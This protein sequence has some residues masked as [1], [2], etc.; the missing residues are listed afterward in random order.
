[1]TEG[2][3]AE[4]LSQQDICFL[5]GIITD[6]ICYVEKEPASGETVLAD[7]FSR[8]FGG[9]GANQCIMAARLGAKCRMLGKVGNDPNGLET[10]K[11]FVEHVV[12]KSAIEIDGSSHTGVALISVEK[13]SGNN[14]I[15]VAQGANKNVDCNYIRFFASVIRR[16]QILMAGMEVPQDAVVEALKIAKGAGRPTILNPAPVPVEVDERIYELADYICPNESEAAQLLGK[17][18][19][20]I[21]TVEDAKAV[22]LELR[23]KGAKTIIITLG[24]KGCVALETDSQEP[25]H[26]EARS[27]T[28]VDT[29]G[30]G[31][32]F[33]GSFAYFV[34]KLPQLSLM[35][36]IKRSGA[37]ASMS[38]Q[39]NGTQLSFPYR[40]ELNP[41]LF[42]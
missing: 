35:E 39:K 15:I 7:E 6:F 37:I 20:T 17:D 12:E 26:V 36:K 24:D 34:C 32:A 4:V 19:D 40:K 18:A 9:K 33:C 11:N 3:N 25:F 22:A 27:V 14:R 28:A 16:C 2:E 1:M 5:G 41:V 38:V 8:G 10:L 21:K 23:A 31:D 13:S 29:T 30:A 42:N